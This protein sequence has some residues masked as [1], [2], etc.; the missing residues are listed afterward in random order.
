MATY[1]QRMKAYQEAK[2]KEE[3]LQ[4]FMHGQ[5]SID[6]TK[7]EDIFYQINK[8]RV[9]MDEFV[10]RDR[11]IDEAKAMHEFKRDLIDPKFGKTQ[12]K[13]NR[14]LGNIPAEIYYARKELSDPNLPPQERQKNII[15]FFNEYPAFRAGDARL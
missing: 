1:E 2:N 5:K 3:F 11:F 4:R 7:S 6:C 12:S 10:N 14:L 15:K 13:H 8:D 9:S